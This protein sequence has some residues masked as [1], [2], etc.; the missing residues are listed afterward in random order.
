VR[1]RVPRK[2]VLGQ[3]RHATCNLQGINILSQENKEVIAATKC[4]ALLLNATCMSDSPTIDDEEE[5]AIDVIDCT[6]SAHTSR[7]VYNA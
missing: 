7:S 2:A 6:L 4:M 1:I 3:A 5:D